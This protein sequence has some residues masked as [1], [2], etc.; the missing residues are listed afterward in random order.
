MLFIHLLAI[1]ILGW[2]VVTNNNIVESYVNRNCKWN[3]SFKENYFEEVKV[4]FLQY[5]GYYDKKQFLSSRLFWSWKE[6]N[7]VFTML[8]CSFWRWL[9]KVSTFSPPCLFW[10]FMGKLLMLNVIRSFE[11]YGVNKS[12]I[13]MWPTDI[14]SDVAI[15]RQKQLCIYFAFLWRE[16]LCKLLQWK[17]KLKMSIVTRYP[18]VKSCITSFV[19]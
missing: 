17:E 14:C 5:N 18:S 4:N 12:L 15:H 19:M 13:L 9:C 8:N 11:S 1:P 10:V 3:F 2:H 7:F 16:L 6:N